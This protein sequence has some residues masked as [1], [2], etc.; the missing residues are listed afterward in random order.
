MLTDSERFAF[1]TRRIH[2]FATT[3]NAYDATQCDETIRTGDTLLVLPEQVVAVAMTWPFAVTSKCGKLHV[4]APPRSGETLELVARA[5]HVCAEDI[6][7]AAALACAMG[8]DLD[9]G[10]ALLLAQRPGWQ[11]RNPHALRR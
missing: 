1:Q 11:W 3:G 8:F 2:A 5:L 10:L 9:P 4:M 6:E 7:H